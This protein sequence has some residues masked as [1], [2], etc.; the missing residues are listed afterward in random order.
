MTGGYTMKEKNIKD[1]AIRMGLISVE[2]TC[3]YT[4]TQL[5]IMV[6]NKVNEL[7]NEVWR[8]ETDVQ[9]ILK[10]Q[11][12]NIQYLLGEGLHLEVVNIFDGWVQDGTF[13]TLLNQSALK[14]VNDR[15]DEVQT[16]TN[17]QLSEKL[18]KNSVLSMA[19][20][21]QDVKEAMTGGS[22]AV[23]GVDT[24]LSENIVNGQVTPKK[25]S[26]LTV[27]TDNLIYGVTYTKGK[28]V[29]PTDGTLYDVSTYQ[30]TS[31]VECVEGQELVFSGTS[32]LCFYNETKTFVE[33][34]QGGQWSS[35]I[36]VPRGAKYFRWC[37]PTADENGAYVTIKGNINITPKIGLND[38]LYESTRDRILKELG[39]LNIKGKKVNV[40]GD[41]ISSI[42]YE[43]PNWC[44]VISDRTGLIFNNY[45][46]SGTTIAYN[47]NRENNAGKC[48]ANRVNELQN[49]DVTIIMGGTND[50]NS[51]IPLG[52]WDDTTNRTLYGA[53]NIIITTLLN[54]FPGKPIIWCSPIQDRNSFK[55]KPTTNLDEKVMNASSSANV[56]YSLLIG[57]IQLKC[58]QYSIPFINLYDDC[59]INGYDNNHIYYRNDD[60]VHPSP[61]GHKMI[62]NAIEPTLKEILK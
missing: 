5:V 51:N 31:F 57:A 28:A 48:F 44:Q 33:G 9:E 52:N 54:K 13:A 50:V 62:A 39:L 47:E 34:K 55:N 16:Q 20:M 35:P 1:L 15:I 26:F 21:G 14:K 22:V 60:T 41:S 2:H 59:G 12:E 61:L 11:N 30:T 6:A 18:N 25:T 4:I 46:V 17:A 10:T 45:G 53:I 8:F 23:V 3:Q 38:E 37:F 7:V 32:N 49:G 56:N 42:D 19:N 40:L 29:R 27:K 36:T 58:R 24:V 43:L